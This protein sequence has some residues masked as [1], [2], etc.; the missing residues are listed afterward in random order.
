M[1]GGKAVEGVLGI[2]QSA[3]EERDAVHHCALP[4]VWESLWNVM[5]VSSSLSFL[6]NQ[7]L[8]DCRSQASHH[9]QPD[10]DQDL[11]KEYL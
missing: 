7:R 10:N 4:R 3:G 11:F 5:Y 2:W 6:Q 9:L 8:W 1:L